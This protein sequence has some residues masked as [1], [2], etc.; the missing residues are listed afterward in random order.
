MIS[1]ENVTKSYHPGKNAV[2][3]LSLEVA[4]GKIIGFIGP[5]GAGKTTTIKMITGILEP[6]SGDIKVCGKSIIHDAIAA[7]REFGYVPDNPD[8][9]LRL[10]G[11]EYLNF[12]AAVYRTPASKKRERI[13]ELA[14]KLEILDALSDKIQTYSHGMRQKLLLTAS[15]MHDPAVW[16][17]DEPLTGL[18]P[19]SSFMLKEMMRN[20]AHSGGT[21]FFSTHVLDVAERL[22]DMVAVI[23]RGKL[24]F[25]G[26][27]D[28]LRRTAG[29]SGADVTLEKIFLDM[30]GNLQ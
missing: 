20:H 14:G 8:V 27:L 3:D 12:I 6:D 7:K 5:N 19:K 1:I 15:L 16:I 18:D 26:A 21:I 11:M 4:P 22:C 28:E 25:Y 13:L 9:F 17:L 23:S 30:T 24:L 2:D 29:E 10:K